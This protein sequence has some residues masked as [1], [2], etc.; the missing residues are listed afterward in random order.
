MDCIKNDQKTTIFVCRLFYCSAD[1][2]LMYNNYNWK[3]MVELGCETNKLRTIHNSLDTSLQSSIFKDLKTSNLFQE[4]FGNDDPVV[5]YIGRIQKR[6]K[7][8]TDFLKQWPWLKNKVSIS[9][10]F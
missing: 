6:K 8:R 9:I 5:I 2:L 1:I 3:Y 7:S 10:W 4:H